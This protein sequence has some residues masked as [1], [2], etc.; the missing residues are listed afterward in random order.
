[1]NLKGDYSASGNGRVVQIDA[2]LTVDEGA[3]AASRGNDFVVVPFAGLDVGF[4]RF[5]LQQIAAVFF[6]EFAPPAAAD[7]GLTA[8]AFDKNGAGS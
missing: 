5:V 4:A 3:D 2:W 7:V 1:M 6:E 8:I